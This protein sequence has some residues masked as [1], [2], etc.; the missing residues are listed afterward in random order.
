MQGQHDRGS[1]RQ[2]TLRTRVGS[3]AGGSSR[4]PKPAAAEGNVAGPRPRTPL[5]PALA[6]RDSRSSLRAR[7]GD[8]ARSNDK[9]LRLEDVFNKTKTKPEI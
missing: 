2:R 4:G 9:P 5:R 6:L 3:A 7:R 8:G 1:A